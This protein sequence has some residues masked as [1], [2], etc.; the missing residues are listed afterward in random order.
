MKGHEYGLGT[1][2]VVDS[3]LIGVTCRSTL[4]IAETSPESS[5]RIPATV[6]T[7]VVRRLSVSE[8]KNTLLQASPFPLSSAAELY[9]IGPLC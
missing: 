4:V 3:D 6:D 8:A 9:E 7:I 2:F 5:D 1:S